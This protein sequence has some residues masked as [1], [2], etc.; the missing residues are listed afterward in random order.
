MLLAVYAVC[1]SKKNNNL[2]V[3]ATV[4]YRIN[5]EQQSTNHSARYKH[6]A[7]PSIS[8]IKPTTKRG[9]YT[10]CLRNLVQCCTAWRPLQFDSYVQ[11]KS[12]INQLRKPRLAKGIFTQ[13]GCNNVLNPI[14]P[15]FTRIHWYRPTILK[16]YGIGFPTSSFVNKSWY[17][18]LNCWLQ[19]FDL[20]K[21]LLSLLLLSLLGL[22][23]WPHEFIILSQ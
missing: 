16:V 15:N 11:P 19:Y 10:L 8:K 4:C 1:V 5:P 20:V 3:W 2:S 14:I 12:A 6:S 17:T 23:Q 7:I 18:K 22:P 21:P 9:V 13:L